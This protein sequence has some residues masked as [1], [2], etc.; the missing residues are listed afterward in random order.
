[1]NKLE[2]KSQDLEKNGMGTV[3]L[4]RGNERLDISLAGNLDLY[5]NL[6]SSNSGNPFIITKDNYPVYLL[7]NKLY[8]NI[9][10][11]Q[12]YPL[13]TKSILKECDLN[14]LDYHLKLQE[15][16]LYYE[17]KINQL[18]TKAKATNLVKDGLI[19]WLSDDYYSEIA[20]Y[21]TL[22]QIDD[23]YVFEFFNENFNNLDKTNL[24]FFFLKLMKQ[25]NYISVRIRN[26]GSFYEPFNICFME[27][28]NS[29]RALSLL[30]YE[31][32]GIEEYQILANNNP[33]R[34][35]LKK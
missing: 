29:L 24:D 27:V 2:L 8:Q 15:A 25:K 7:F 31:Q 6:Y 13:D 11:G 34:V 20:P 18:K 16:E 35:L 33:Q 32:I 5:F 30:D 19:T 10:S 4:I 9:I 3:S 23:Y 22:K 26:S 17:E 21:F 28:Y 12:I 1:M 14:N